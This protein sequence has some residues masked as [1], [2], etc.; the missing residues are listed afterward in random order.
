MVG[1]QK[2]EQEA[3]RASLCAGRP[4]FFDHVVNF[5]I[6][7][8]DN[9]LSICA[10][11]LRHFETVL[12]WDERRRFVG[13][14]IVHLGPNLPADF[15]QIAKAFGCDQSDVCAPTLDERVGGDGRA[16]CEPANVRRR[17]ALISRKVVQSGEN[18][19]RGIIRCRGAFMQANDGVIFFE[20]VEIR[21]RAANIDA[22]KPNHTCYPNYRR[23]AEALNIRMS[24]WVKPSTHYCNRH[25]T[26]HGNPILNTVRYVSHAY[27]H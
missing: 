12:S 21:K 17:Y 2:S 15:Q 6:G 9:D 16:V 4:D 11:P 1:I 18:C 20:C 13:L 25:L 3:D 22:D 14:K 26:G 7:K 24:I 27:R 10:D 23:A 5:F 19:S 8:V